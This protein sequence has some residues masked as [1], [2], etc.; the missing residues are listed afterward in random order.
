MLD[1]L[2]I[3]TLKQKSKISMNNKNCWWILFN[4]SKWSHVHI[5]ACVEKVYY[6]N[7][8]WLMLPCVDMRPRSYISLKIYLQIYSFL[9]LDANKLLTGTHELS[10]ILVVKYF[11][12]FGHVNLFICLPQSLLD[13]LQHGKFRCYYWKD[14]N[15]R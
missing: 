6:Q 10:S 15:S 14:N 8:A 11:W 7:I 1:S 13:I 2:N 4:L 12:H 5:K 9:I 3:L